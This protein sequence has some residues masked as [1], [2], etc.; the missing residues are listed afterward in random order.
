MSPTAARQANEA[1]VDRLIGLGALWSPPLIAAFR[2][3]PRHLFLHRVYQY[4]RRAGRWREVPGRDPGPDVLRLLYADRALITRLSPGSRTEG[5]VPISSS[6]Q[7]SLMAQMLEDLKPGPGQRVLEV[8]AGTG[9]NAALLA[10][11]AGPGQVWSIDVD[12]QV[13]SEAWDHLH[14][15]AGRRVELRHAD[16]RCGYAEAAPFD[17]VMVTAATPDLEPAWLEQL[18]PGGLLLAPLALAPGLAFVVCG[19]VADGI[20][21]GRLTRAAFFMPLRSEGETGGAGAEAPRPGPFT[22]LPAPW[23]D[24]FDRKRSRPGWLGFIQALAFYALL[25][26]LRLS[27]QALADG[28]ATFGVADPDERTWCWLGEEAWHVTGEAGR[29]LGVRL[30][31]AFLDAGGPWPTEF[32]LRASPC[33]ELAVGEG[34]EVYERQGPRCRQVWE[35]VEP[36]ERPAWL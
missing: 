34:R 7:P 35:L 11:A 28:E 30:W 25:R 19:G 16:G 17:R 3:T 22:T 15:F 2:E 4:Q 21:E 31:R 24:W 27:Y 6:S 14:S 8:G 12:R 5:P 9:Y 10:H 20:F 33:G 23:A 13:L 1:M 36:R 32:R 18:A 26:G 29:E